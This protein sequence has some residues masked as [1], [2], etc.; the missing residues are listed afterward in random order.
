MPLDKLIDLLAEAAVRKLSQKREAET[1]TP[2]DGCSGY[3]YAFVWSR[4]FRLYRLYF[5]EIVGGMLFHRIDFKERSTINP[6]QHL[7]LTPEGPASSI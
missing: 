6:A 5:V 4:F 1:A 2:D 7:C 3:P